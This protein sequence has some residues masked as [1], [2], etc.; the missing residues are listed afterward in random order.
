MVVSLNG[1]SQKWDSSGKNKQTLLYNLGDGNII[2]KP[3]FISM[4]YIDT[5]YFISILRSSYWCRSYILW[6][7]NLTWPIFLR[8]GINILWN[9]LWEMLPTFMGLFQQIKMITALDYF[10][11]SRA[12]VCSMLLQE[13]VLPVSKLH[14]NVF[15]A[16][17][18]K[19]ICVESWTHP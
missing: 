17:L 7:V 8:W 14:P 16:L 4:K 18:I 15:K 11:I 9:T 13:I 6:N 12:D 2:V 10:L 5:S 19:Y 3:R 1:S